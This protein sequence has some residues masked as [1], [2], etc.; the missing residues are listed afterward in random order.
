[1][2]LRSLRKLRR[3]IRP[4]SL[5]P[6]WCLSAFYDFELMAVNAQ[7]GEYVSINNSGE[8]AY[9]QGPTSGNAVYVAGEQGEQ[10][11]VSYGPET[12]RNHGVAAA[13]ND[14]PDGND[15]VVSRSRY[16]VHDTVRRW[17]DDGL[18]SP[19][20]QGLRVACG[21]TLNIACWYEP[22]TFQGFAQFVDI[23]DNNDVVFFGVDTTFQP[24]HK[25][26]VRTS[27]ATAYVGR[28]IT[29]GNFP[30]DTGLRP[31]I[32]NTTEVV[33]RHT[34][35]TSIL[36]TD[37]G[38]GRFRRIAG[39]HEGFVGLDDVPAVGRSPGISDD[40]RVIVFFGNH[41]AAGPGIYASILKPQGDRTSGSEDRWIV[42]L[43][44]AAHARLGELENDDGEIIEIKD[45]F[46]GHLGKNSNGTYPTFAE[47]DTESRVGIGGNLSYKP[48]STST[49]YV[50]FLADEGLYQVQLIAEVDDQGNP[51]F[52][53]T[54][55]QNLV[56]VDDTIRG[57]QIE[58]IQLYDPVNEHGTVGFW[59]ELATGEHAVFRATTS[60]DTDG[61]GLLDFWETDGLDI[62]DDGTIDLNLAEMGAKVGQRDLF[63]EL[64][65]L[66]TPSFDTRFS[67][68]PQLG[69]LG[70]MVRAFRRAPDEPIELHIDAG[71]HSVNYSG[72]RFGGDQLPHADVV[73][74]GFGTMNTPGVSSASFAQLKASHSGGQTQQARDAREYVFH[75]GILGDFVAS[76]S[77]ELPV[78]T[79]TALE[80]RDGLGY[81]RTAQ[82]VEV[83]YGDVVKMVSGPNAGQYRVIQEVQDDEWQLTKTWDVP[84]TAG[85]E[86]VLLKGSTTGTAEVGF[87]RDLI[88][89]V[90]PT[91]TYPN[92]A[93]NRPIP[94]N[95]FIVSY[96]TY[97]HHQGADSFNQYQTLMHELG[98]NLGL[99]HGGNDH[100]NYKID[101]RSLMNYEY[102]G[103]REV[104]SYADGNDPVYDDWS[105]LQFDFNH[106]NRYL[107]NSDAS[108]FFELHHEDEP[109][110]NA[111]EYEQR[112]GPADLT[113]PEITDIRLADTILPGGRLDVEV[114]VEGLSDGEVLLAF[115][116]DGDSIV[117]PV[118]Y[119][120]AT[121]VDE[122]TYAASFR[123]LACPAGQR[124]LSV[125]ARDAAWNSTAREQTVEIEDAPCPPVAHDDQGLVEQF[126]DAIIDVILND[127]NANAAALEIV[128][129]PQHV[130]A[131]LT[132][133]GHIR[134]IASGDYLGADSLQYR[135]SVDGRESGLATLSVRV[136]EPGSIRRVPKILE[137]SPSD[138]MR[139][140][141]LGKIEVVFDSPMDLATVTQTSHYQL[142]QHD[143]TIGISSVDYH[144]QPGRYVATL[145][146][147]TDAVFASGAISLLVDGAQVKSVLG[148]PLGQGS[149]D[150][151]VFQNELNAVS[152]LGQVDAGAFDVKDVMSLGKD[153]PSNVIMD[154]F[155]GN[156]QSD[157]VIMSPATTELILYP[158]AADGSLGAATSIELEHTPTQMVKVDWNQ[159][160]ALDLLVAESVQFRVLLNDGLG[161]FTDAP[162]TPI[163]IAPRSGIGLADVI[164]D[165]QPEIIQLGNA[166]S[167][168]IIGK[169]PFLGYEV[170]RQ[171]DRPSEYGYNVT[172]GD[173][174]GDGIVDVVAHTQEA[175]VGAAPVFN[176]FLGTANGFDSGTPLNVHGGLVKGLVLQAKDFN[177]DGHLDLLGI[178]DRYSGFQGVD[179]GLVIH[180][181]E[182]HGDGTFTPHDRIAMGARGVNL[183]AVEDVDHDGHLD[184]IFQAGPWHREWYNVTDV[185]ALWIWKGDGQ[186]SFSE[187]KAP[188]P[189]PNN[190]IATSF[191]LQ[192]IDGDGWHDLV[193]GFSTLPQPDVMMGGPNLTWTAM[194]NG[195][196]K[197]GAN[198]EFG[199]RGD[200]A[201]GIADFDGDGAL[202]VLA[203]NQQGV[204]LRQQTDG[205]W[206]PIST[207]S[208][209]G[210]DAAWLE[211]GDI[212]RD[213]SPDIVYGM[214]HDSNGHLG[215][216]LNDGQGNLQLSPQGTFTPQGFQAASNGRLR[217][218]N[219][220]GNLDLIVGLNRQKCYWY[221][222]SSQSAAY[223]VL[224]G[225]GTGNLLFSVNS[226]KELG[227]LDAYRGRVNV[228]D[229]NRDQIPDL[230]ISQASTSQVHLGLGNGLFEPQAA[231][232]KGASDKEDTYVAGDFNEDGHLDLVGFAFWQQPRLQLYTGD[233]TGQFTRS[234]RLDLGY[235]P[236]DV[237]AGD[238]NGD[239]HQD[240]AVTGNNEV[241]FYLGDGTG[242]FE[243]STRQLGGTPWTLALWPQANLTSVARWELD[244]V[245][246][247]V[248]VTQTE[249]Q[250]DAWVFQGTGPS[251]GDVALYY[252]DLELTTAKADNE[253][254]WTATVPAT[255]L[256]AGLQQFSI[257]AASSQGATP[258]SSFTADLNATAGW[259]N[260]SN[261]LD[262]SADD[263]ITP[264]DVLLVINFLNT[265]GNDGQ[266][267]QPPETPP[268][269][270]D[271]NGDGMVTP[272]DVLLV[273][274][275]LNDREG[276]GEFGPA[277][278]SPFLAD[279]DFSS[280]SANVRSDEGLLSWLDEQYDL[281]LEN[282][283][284]TRPWWEELWN[285][286]RP[287]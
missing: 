182:G 18:K 50:V 265:P 43:A 210:S 49:L 36:K 135:L 23:N 57:E 131:E 166:P 75:Y 89:P 197:G 125:V 241:R 155:T 184:L 224:F 259:H 286:K 80:N 283:R 144:E 9:V 168:S 38:D 123:G 110:S 54:D 257:Q 60:P 218:L 249:F 213:G 126:Q 209:P 250:G 147:E 146:V 15:V 67:R 112:Y 163:P 207:L 13:I 96:G 254:K 101:Y 87:A 106:Y 159:D 158:R 150:V 92:A 121:A 58:R 98:H 247:P 95:D 34:N 196:P 62:D 145:H 230:I 201:L 117:S 6:R 133:E 129:P 208:V 280:K 25:L 258:R 39:A 108:S 211:V 237:L 77:A 272:L 79:S 234:T 252:N 148:V 236:A 248:E 185:Q 203:L 205:S 273:I 282:L 181:L 30:V 267:P 128:T 107:F 21:S 127:D 73:H 287:S 214:F 194:K 235:N 187:A 176:L 162:E 200:E 153:R 130:T 206:S 122:N 42:P 219:G 16:Q 221:G 137:L 238:F 275:Y 193:L 7:I 140:T 192:D 74:F 279:E 68:G 93:S 91:F 81:L 231:W 100:T 262:V 24:V 102:S 226:V 229:V 64:D 8:I 20:G 63:V 47:Y 65:W 11:L 245:L 157:L 256:E 190:A 285:R 173:F 52:R 142:T 10:R 134:V 111:I 86:F 217:D 152:R 103:N 32:S 66:E 215:V 114:D 253:G 255:E 170:L 88:D 167:I 40:G 2:K 261:P 29:I 239:N 244:A 227:F 118:E 243:L 191:Q 85:D 22:D 115:D 69:V 189:F 138:G 269:F 99:R 45:A 3:L 270:Y 33:F 26:R 56:S 156:G 179:E 202:D 139:V 14:A 284:L 171:I 31:Q 277:V 222:C 246:S 177:H 55:P 271:V 178:E 82:A 228:E 48:G 124:I 183:Q 61:D 186:G 132:D 119:L 223:G 278:P 188:I 46:L 116:V 204:I 83:R 165:S 28:E 225:D 266:L 149:S 180:F 113:P 264:L 233:S 263:L 5:E 169:S 232:P 268:P 198:V 71:I 105:N 120:V 212:N 175:G 70:D 164:G 35:Q 240:I 4:E 154:D 136:V 216:L 143:R 97:L 90:S 160:G 174:N 37:P 276:E 12:E 94:G 53:T 141:T 41:A 72:P 161:R 59:A 172:T 51:T 220:D 76:S 281:S 1:M 242:T 199:R 274:N 195:L 19:D 27:A 78:L 44:G 109:A 260:G 251:S 151:A 84:S 17:T 104:A